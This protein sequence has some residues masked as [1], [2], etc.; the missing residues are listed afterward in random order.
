MKVPSVLDRCGSGA[1]TNNTHGVSLGVVLA[2]NSHCDIPYVGAD[3]LA[4]TPPISAKVPRPMLVWY[5]TEAGSRGTSKR[6]PRIGKR[7]RIVDTVDGED[8]RGGFKL[9]AIV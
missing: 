2:E 1:S 4:V 9:T 7:N 6:G 8:V 3:I 5:G